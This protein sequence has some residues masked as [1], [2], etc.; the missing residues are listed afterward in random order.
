MK[1]EDGVGDYGYHEEDHHPPAYDEPAHCLVQLAALYDTFPP[2]AYCV[3]GQLS[4]RLS[5]PGEQSEDDGIQLQPPRTA[6][7]NEPRNGEYHASGAEDAED[8]YARV[9]YLPPEFNI[10][11]VSK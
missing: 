2:K 10:G 8:E 1:V 6:H 9:A 5:S 3:A 4:H 7:R 11:D